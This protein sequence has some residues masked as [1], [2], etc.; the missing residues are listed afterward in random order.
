MI[1]D[2][3]DLNFSNRTQIDLK[4]KW[5]NMQK[6]V[7]YAQRPLR[8][9]KLLDQYHN[10]ILTSSGNPHIYINRWPRDAAS[11]VATKSKFYSENFKSILI[12]LKETFSTGSNPM[13]ENEGDSIVHVYKGT[14]VMQSAASIEK[15]RGAKTMWVARVSK[16]REERYIKRT[17]VEKQ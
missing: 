13:D 7:T 12:F 6:Y 15:F 4:D 9:Y 16:I 3:P 2:D 8:H 5:R 1:L 11:K 10:P 17:D 14:R